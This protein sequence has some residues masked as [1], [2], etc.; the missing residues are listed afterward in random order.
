MT[1]LSLALSHVDVGTEEFLPSGFGQ[2]TTPNRSAGSSLEIRS[3]DQ[4]VFD[5]I[6]ESISPLLSALYLIGAIGF[7]AVLVFNAFAG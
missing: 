6:F 3:V 2:G 7:S 1:N 5:D 4:N